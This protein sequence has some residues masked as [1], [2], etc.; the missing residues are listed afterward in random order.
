MKNYPHSAIG[1]EQNLL[2]P[3]INGWFAVLTVVLLT[4]VAA[5]AQTSPNQSLDEPQ[6]NEGIEKGWNEFGI[7]GSVSFHAPTLIGKTPEARFANLGLRY[8]RVLSAS[9]NVAFEYTIDVIPVAVLSL[10]RF[11]AV[12]VSPGVTRAAFCCCNRRISL[13]LRAS[14]GRRCLPV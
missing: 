1:K 12:P 4:V 13:L 10:K 3:L 9:K 7:W 6:S 8:G 14:S 5:P 11:T 2:A